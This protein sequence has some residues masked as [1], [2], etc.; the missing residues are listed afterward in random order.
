MTPQISAMLYRRVVA[1]LAFAALLVGARGAEEPMRRFDSVEVAP[2]KTSIYV[3]TV[4]LTMATFTRV[5]GKF[6]ADFNAKVFPYF[7][8]SEKGKVTIDFPDEALTRLSKGE[9]VEFK[10]EAVSNGG[11]H[12]RVEGR[13]TPADAASGKLKFKVF[14]LTNTELIFNTTYRLPA[15]K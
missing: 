15:A 10:G 14:V 7:F 3:G 11:D 6:Q 5:D 1:L 4:S 13:A 2:G 9:T 8:Y 12:H